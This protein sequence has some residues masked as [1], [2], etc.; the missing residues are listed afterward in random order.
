MRKCISPCPAHGSASHPLP[1]APWQLLWAQ[2]PRWSLHVDGARL[3]W[4]KLAFP[5]G[6]CYFLCTGF[7]LFEAISI[8][9]W[10]WLFFLKEKNLDRVESVNGW[11]TSGYWKVSCGRGVDFIRLVIRLVFNYRKWGTFIWGIVLA[12][13]TYGELYPIPH[14]LIMKWFFLCMYTLML[15]TRRLTLC[16][17]LAFT[18]FTPSQPRVGLAWA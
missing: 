10:D 5:P 9:N 17:Y 7:V 12:N 6:L 1:G 4:P 15:Y 13:R 18:F 11:R 3:F 16:I 8:F 2:T 14:S